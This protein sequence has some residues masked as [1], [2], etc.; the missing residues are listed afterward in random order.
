MKSNRLIYNSLNEMLHEQQEDWFFGVYK[1]I[2][3]IDFTVEQ[4]V[5]YNLTLTNWMLIQKW[6]TSD[7]TTI[8]NKL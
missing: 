6:F 4:D 8:Q 5:V 7:P 2:S 3:D 1:K